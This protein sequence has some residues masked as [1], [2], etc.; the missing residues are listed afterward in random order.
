LAAVIGATVL[1]TACG[2]DQT[3]G[4][5]ALPASADLTQMLNCK[6]SASLTA[7]DAAFRLD[8]SLPAL[9]HVP[10]DSLHML[11]GTPP[12]QDVSLCDLV[13]ASNKQMALVTFISA[14]CYDCMKWLDQMQSD[15]ATDKLD[16]S[17]LLVAVMVDSAEETSD[18]D[19][20]TMQ[21]QVAPNAVWVR[22]VNEGMWNF[23]STADTLNPPVTPLTIAMDWA[24]RGFY[25]DTAFTPLKTLVQISDT[26]MSLTIA[27][28]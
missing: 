9:R 8:G 2:S 22:D 26:L 27:A 10:A 23:F 16:G 14:E 4:A 17:V 20:A 1:A 6:G 18:A 12:A 19:L 21:A 11:Q 5:G 15:L 7:A 28:N 24:A 13:R 3:G 25:C